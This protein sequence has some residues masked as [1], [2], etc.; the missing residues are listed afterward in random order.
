MDASGAFAALDRYGRERRPCFFAFDFAQAHPVVLPLDMVDPQRIRF[1]LRGITN[2]RPLPDPAAALVLPRPAELLTGIIPPSRGAYAAAFAAAREA[3]RAG[4][5]YLL[6]L[7]AASSVR[8]AMPLERLYGLARAPY[9]L[10]MDSVLVFSPEAFVRIEA[11]RIRTFPMKGSLRCPR[12]AAAQGARRLLDDPKETAE[13]V[14]VVDLLRNDLGRVAV[15]V[16]VPRYRYVEE[17]FLGDE[18][19][20]QTSSE[21]E[22]RLEA[23][24]PDRLG[25][26]LAALLPAGSVTGAPK[27]RTCEHIARAEA[28]LGQERGWYT[29]VFGVF[30]GEAVDSAVMIR[31]IEGASPAPDGQGWQATFKSGGGLTW[32][33]REDDE[34]AE[35]VAK[36][37]FPRALALMETVRVTDG[38]PVRL[39]WHLRRMA[40]GARAVWGRELGYDPRSMLEGA[41]A[42]ARA[43]L[44]DDADRSL[45]GRWRFRLDY[46]PWGAVRAE[47]VPYRPRRPAVLYLVEAGGL[48]YPAKLA[49]RGGIDAL[50][51]R[52]ASAIQAGKLAEP[53]GDWDILL[54]EGER[55]LE[56][57]YAALLVPDGA[58]WLTPAR[59]RVAST[60]LAALAAERPGLVAPVELDATGL[61]AAGRVRLVNA[62]LDPEDAVDVSDLRDARWLWRQPGDA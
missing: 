16:S 52:V 21:I 20:I 58:A 55:V 33:S 61:L 26:I 47:L 22:G 45:A 36:V 39:D 30:T 1:D 9:R 23:N 14:T 5:S 7:T 37:A 46:D 17:V 54:C 18:V 2:G 60:R 25:A 8:L 50:K 11:D 42:A 13:H 41:F 35:L 15:A 32:D 48:D 57:G 44:P 10:L 31:F 53:G 43:A 6:N 38:R 34:Y 59:P 3:F 24:W 51:A 49:G 29:G 19:L 12:Q 28:L 56:A 4:D 40:E 62:M 27:K